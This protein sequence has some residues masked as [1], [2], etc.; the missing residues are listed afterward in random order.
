VPQV[1]VDPAGATH[2]VAERRL[3]RVRQWRRGQGLPE[4]DARLGGGIDGRVRSVAGTMMS[5]CDASD[6]AQV[7]TW[8]VPAPG[9]VSNTAAFGTQSCLNI[10]GCDDDTIM[11]YACVMGR[12]C[13]SIAR[14]RHAPRAAC[15]ARRSAGRPT[16]FLHTMHP[17]TP[18]SAAA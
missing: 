1:V 11:F 15:F 5:P 14:P 10:G 6:P 13:W 3:E 4:A 18:H 12:R 7:W 2:R 16:R 17:H 8:D 9:Y